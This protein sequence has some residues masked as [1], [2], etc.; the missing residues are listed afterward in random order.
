MF[1]GHYGMSLGA[2][3]IDAR[4]SSGWIFLAVRQL[5]GI[6]RGDARG[7]SLL[8]SEAHGFVHTSTLTGLSDEPTMEKAT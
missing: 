5:P 6:F 7:G 2:K 1:V 8:G 3:R 4:L